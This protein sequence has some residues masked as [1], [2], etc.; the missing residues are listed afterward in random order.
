[1]SMPE[2]VKQKL[3]RTQAERNKYLLCHQGPVQLG[4]GADWWE[5]GNRPPP[6]FGRHTTV[7]L[8][9]RGTRPVSAPSRWAFPVWDWSEFLDGNKMQNREGTPAV[10]RLK[11]AAFL[12]TDFLQQRFPDDSRTVQEWVF[13]RGRWVP[14]VYLAFPFEPVLCIFFFLQLDP[15]KYLVGYT[16]KFLDH[17]PE[18]T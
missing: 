2:D 15:R 9:S 10:V 17:Q 11:W 6:E 4:T 5:E 18:K 7:Y 14:Q 8:T 3:R 16:R 12:Q 13:V 1:M